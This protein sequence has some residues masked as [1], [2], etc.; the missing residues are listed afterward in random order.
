[1]QQSIE[2]AR[3]N[4]SVISKSRVALVVGA[5]MLAAIAIFPLSAWAEAAEW[6]HAVQHI[7]I[8]SAGAALGGGLFSKRTKTGRES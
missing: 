5:F 4:N 2:E 3:V 7:L 1:M 6:H 8:F